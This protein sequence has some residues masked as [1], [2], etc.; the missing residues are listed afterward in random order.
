MTLGTLC[1]TRHSAAISRPQEGIFLH[2]VKIIFAS[3]YPSKQ[4]R[5]LVKSLTLTQKERREKVSETF[6][7]VQASE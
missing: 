7:H 2:A 6:D 3:F 5:V 4:E 1:L